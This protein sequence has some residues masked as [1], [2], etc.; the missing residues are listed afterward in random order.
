MTT[1]R[2]AQTGNRVYRGVGQSPNMGQV[3]AQGA[4]GYLKRELRNRN[5]G[6]VVRPVGND[7]KSDS[8]SG[9]AARALR[10]G[11]ISGNLGNNVG[12]PGA[13]KNPGRKMQGTKS[14]LNQGQ[15]QGQ[16]VG[17]TPSPVQ[18]PQVTVN[19]NGTL[20]LPYSQNMSS[21]AIQALNE[22]NEELLNLQMEEQAMAQEAMQGRR[23]ADIAF[24]ELGKQNL[25]T[26]ASGGTAFSSKYGKDVA[27]T[28]TAYS[29]TLSDIS[30]R[31]A[32][33]NQNA[34][35]RRA[36]IQRSLNEQLAA[37]AQENQFDLTEDAGSLG[38]GQYQGD[39]HS[40]DKNRNKNKNKN[41]PKPPPKKGTGVA[42]AKPGKGKRK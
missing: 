21:A 35:L 25:S 32:D 34:A 12:R 31:E 23:D 40:H 22:S 7:G 15:G 4:Q 16:A 26:N 17:T 6:G 42:P 1:F 20:E 14:P 38:Y 30:R 33:F 19:A 41:K 39:T 29:N 24:K 11:Q 28:S 37:A 9:A 13:N 5:Q 2:Q 8:R 3:S 27:D 36:T 10:G 18:I